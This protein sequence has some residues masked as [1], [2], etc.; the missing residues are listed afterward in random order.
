M[1]RLTM[2]LRFTLHYL[3]VLI[4]YGAAADELAFKR[5]LCYG[6][7]GTQSEWIIQELLG[8]HV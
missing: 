7:T 2:M 6:E 1:V 3:Q 4:T 8:K 5:A